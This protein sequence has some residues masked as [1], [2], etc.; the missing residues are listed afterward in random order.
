VH[1]DT[2]L[3]MLLTAI[4]VSA[5]PLYVLFRA[6]RRIRDLEMALLA[7]TTD[8]E[9]LGDVREL[10]ERLASQTEQLA[11]QQALLASRLAERHDLL[12]PPRGEGVR[13]VTPH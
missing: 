1:A 12:P 9:Q 10:L 11:D 6:H 4:G 8:M 7:R 2:V 3:L 5:A 13:P